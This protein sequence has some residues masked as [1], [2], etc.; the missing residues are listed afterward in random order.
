MTISLPNYN[1]WSIR[2]AGTQ[3]IKNNM[4]LTATP[5]FALQC[6]IRKVHHR[7]AHEGCTWGWVVSATPWLLYSRERDGLPIV[8]EAEWIPESV[9]IGAENL[10]HTGIQSSDRIACRKFL[11]NNTVLAHALFVISVMIKVKKP[12]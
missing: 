3:F 4:S 11:S 12:G 9:W 2:V 6:R 7:T 1:A 10:S 8:Q 5:V